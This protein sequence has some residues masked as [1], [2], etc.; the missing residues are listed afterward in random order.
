MLPKIICYIVV[1]KVLKLAIFYI[2]CNFVIFYI[3]IICN[4]LFGSS[5]ITTSAQQILVV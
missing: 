1:L 2:F 4:I 5:Q 3:I